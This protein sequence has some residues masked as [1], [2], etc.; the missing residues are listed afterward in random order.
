MEANIRQT[1]DKD[2]PSSQTAF[3]KIVPVA[4]CV[5]LVLGGIRD[6]SADSATYIC[7]EVAACESYYTA[8]GGSTTVST[9]PDAY[10]TG[11]AN[12]M[13]V[14]TAANPTN[15]TTGSGGCVLI[16]TC[17]TCNDGYEL[18][19]TTL[20][21][22]FNNGNS[23]CTSIN[24][25]YDIKYCAKNSDVTDPE[26]TRCTAENC[27]S[28][29]GWKHHDLTY[30]K[31][32]LRQCGAD[33]V[34]CIESTQY[35]CNQGY[36][37]NAGSDT[38]TG[39]VACP[40]YFVNGTSYETTS[41]VTAHTS[42]DACFIKAVGD[43]T[44]FKDHKGTYVLTPYNSM[45]TMCYYNLGNCNDYSW[46]C[47]T[48]SGTA[49]SVVS[50]DKANDTSGQYCWCNANGNSFFMTNL[51]S[52]STCASSCVTACQNAM[53]GHVGNGYQAMVSLDALGCF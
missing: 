53:V 45:A 20:P 24:S 9:I 43:T 52:A 33:G 16:P 4:M 39:C 6:V 21:V 30:V 22:L 51:G 47:T 10:I 40:P 37:G 11:C 36:Y 15:T 5:A 8:N 13:W 1:R 50:G 2:L 28:D 48:N 12:A 34:T 44:E 7:S 23:A 49:F 19:D 35:A 25:S 17:L 26:E 38:A 31:R 27:V 18:A 3:Y 46:A 29:T 14:T 41:T 32:T 42:I